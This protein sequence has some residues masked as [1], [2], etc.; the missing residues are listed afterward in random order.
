MFFRGPYFKA[1]FFASL[2][3]GLSTPAVEVPFDNAAPERTASV[4][5]V[6]RLAAADVSSRLAAVDVV[7]RSVSVDLQTRTQSV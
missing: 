7:S 5:V 4:D 2:F 3:F 6:S 1:R